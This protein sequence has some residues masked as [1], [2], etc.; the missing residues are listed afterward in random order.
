MAAA[1][2]SPSVPSAPMK[3][4]FR[5][6][7]VVSFLSGLRTSRISPLAKTTSRPRTEPWSEPYLRYRMPPALVEMLPPMWQLPLAPRSRGIIRPS[8]ARVS[9]K[10]CRMQ[11]A[12][13]TM[14]PASGSIDLISSILAMLTTTSSNTGTL[15]PTRPVF[16]PWGTTARLRSEQ[17]RMM[18]ETSSVVLGR[19]ASLDLPSYLFIQ[20]RLKG[21][22]SSAS[23]TTCFG[24]PRMEVK[25]SR[26]PAVISLKSPLTTGLAVVAR[27]RLARLAKEPRADMA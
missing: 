13:Q 3:S 2:T 12:W 21:K 18:R 27:H 8:L 15:P 11:P 6:Y 22:R 14:T 16:P 19:R 17:C 4:C 25:A 26:S 7:P 10:C 5:S 1:V 9:S 23:V 24:S 20:S